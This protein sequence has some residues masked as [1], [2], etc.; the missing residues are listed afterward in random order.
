MELDYRQATAGETG[1]GLTMLK[2][3]AEAIKPDNLSYLI[4]SRY[5]TPAFVFVRRLIPYIYIINP[6][7]L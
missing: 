2:E 3:A 1:S 4:K 5:N 6:P 7:R